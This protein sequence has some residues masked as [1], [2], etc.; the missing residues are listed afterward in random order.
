MGVLIQG[1]WQEK[2]YN[3]KS[4]HFIRDQSHF[5]HWIGADEH[6]NYSAEPGRYHLY[7]SLAC[8]WASGTLMMRKFKKL[9]EVIS[10]SIVDPLMLEGGWRFS[11]RPDCIADYI[12]N[13]DY[14]HEVYTLAQSDYSGRVTVPV[15]WDKKNHTIVSNESQD[16]MRMLN[17]AFDS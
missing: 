2:A 7:A 8:P 1:Q 13:K 16:I 12:N 4:G 15:L 10:L 9:E 17:D 11:E 3:T 5:R 6:G 14:L